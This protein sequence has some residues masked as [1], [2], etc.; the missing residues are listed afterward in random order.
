MVDGLISD[1]YVRAGVPLHRAGTIDDMGGLVLF[2]TSRV[3][4]SSFER[5]IAS[6]TDL[7]HVRRRVHTSTERFSLSTAA[8]CYCIPQATRL[9]ARLEHDRSPSGYL[10][11]KY[12]NTDRSAYT[13]ITTIIPQN[14]QYVN[15]SLYF[16]PTPSVLRF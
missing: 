7:V 13:C 3:R 15:L 9:A 6:W 8:V 16:S 4:S 1:E 5:L 12:S 14:L 2:L 10:I 11:S